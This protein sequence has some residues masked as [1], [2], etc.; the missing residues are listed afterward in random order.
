MKT[1]L[2]A[3]ACTALMALASTAQAAPL[4]AHQCNS[5]P[6]VRLSGPV[7]Q[8]QLQRELAE[9]QSVGYRGMRDND[10]PHLLHVAERRLNAKYQRD[11]VDTGIAHG[12]GPTGI[13]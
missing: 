3:L 7:T 2:P 10:Y 12:G 9:L 8:R 1:T 6:F 11:C 4:T 13:L 5:Y